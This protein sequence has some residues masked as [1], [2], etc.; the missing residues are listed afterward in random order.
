MT[1][2]TVTPDWAESAAPGDVAYPTSK[3]AGGY[4]ATDTMEHDEYNALLQNHGQW[5][6]YIR[7]GNGGRVA[8]LAEALAATPAD[9]EVFEVL[10]A[11]SLISAGVELPFMASKQSMTVGGGAIDLS[12]VGTNGAT[13]ATTDGTNLY[14]WADNST[15]VVTGPDGIPAGTPVSIHINHQYILVICSAE[16]GLYDLDGNELD[17][18]VPVGTYVAGC[19]ASGDLFFA[20]D[21]S[22][23]Y[24]IDTS[25]GTI[26]STLFYAHGGPSITGLAS[27]GSQVFLNGNANG[28]G[29]TGASIGMATGSALWTSTSMQVGFHLITDGTRLYLRNGVNDVYCYDTLT[30]NELDSNLTFFSSTITAMALDDEYLYVNTLTTGAPDVSD[31]FVICK[32]DLSVIR[33]LQ[34]YSSYQAWN[35]DTAAAMRS[36]VAT[37]TQLVMVGDSD[38]TY[39]GSVSVTS[40]SPKRFVY[41]DGDAAITNGRLFAPINLSRGIR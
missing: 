15:T 17:T 9:R 8:S 38:G 24:E 14:I 12:V 18:Q 31:L 13:H 10:P 23:V 1:R 5:L 28:S 37:G 7:Q 30:G 34:L 22:T 25:A 26:V 6:E 21:S 11:T 39:N 32:T 4:Q 29:E 35:T 2:P 20:G 27:D 16:M 3:Q 41:R 40:M 19:W 33:S 36:M